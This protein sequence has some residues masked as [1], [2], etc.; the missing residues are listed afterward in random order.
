MSGLTRANVERADNS[1]GRTSPDAYKCRTV[2][3][4]PGSSSRE[5]FWLPRVAP[6]PTYWYTL[7]VVA[8]TTASLRVFQISYRKPTIDC[9]SGKVKSCLTYRSGEGARPGTGNENPP[10]SEARAG[11][12]RV[13]SRI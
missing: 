13:V 1:L 5:C 8:A 2:S 11:S 4:S 9:R 12:T 7:V 6:S 3:S 10:A